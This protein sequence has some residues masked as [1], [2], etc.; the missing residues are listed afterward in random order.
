MQ[1]TRQR[2]TR[3]LRQ[4]RMGVL[5]EAGGRARAAA[6]TEIRALTTGEAKE[7]LA[8]TLGG[9]MTLTMAPGMLPLKTAVRK[10][11]AS[12]GPEPMQANVKQA[13]ERMAYIDAC[14]HCG[15]CMVPVTCHVW[16]AEAVSKPG[17]K[18]CRKVLTKLVL[19]DTLLC[20][21]TLRPCHYVHSVLLSS[22]SALQGGVGIA[23]KPAAKVAAAGVVARTWS[24]PDAC[25]GA[26][27][28][29]LS[30]SESSS[31]LLYPSSSKACRL[32]M[33]GTRSRLPPAWRTGQGAVALRISQ[34]VYCC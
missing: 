3:A 13:C 8:G 5:M 2:Q 23:G 25:L 24:A 34:T 20:L 14:V 22:A 11:N 16:C 10:S 12:P 18:Q 19:W 30:A 21:L 29:H 31:L 1:G 32:I 6:A 4:T 27:G 26:L 9:R 28:L 17:C 7:T 33:P 15:C